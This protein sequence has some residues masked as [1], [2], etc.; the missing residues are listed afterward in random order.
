VGG[1]NRLD[2]NVDH[3]RVGLRGKKWFPIFAFGIDGAWHLIKEFSAS[4]D[5]TC[6]QF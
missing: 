5:F 6:C 3:F 1:V 2:E 4:K